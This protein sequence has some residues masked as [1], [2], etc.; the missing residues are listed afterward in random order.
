MELG[1]RIK[2]YRNER[3]LSQDELAE[4]VFV[5]R[6]TVSNW[7]T[8]KTYPDINSLLLLS[9]AFCVSLDQ[10]VKGDIEIMKEEID[11]QEFAQ[12]QRDSAIYTVLFIAL[13]V[14][15]IPLAKF[16]GWWGGAAYLILIAV[17]MY[18]AVR[19]EK[20]KK[21]YDIQTY[22]EIVAFTEGRSMDDIEKARESGKRPYQKILLAVGSALLCFAFT[23]LMVWLLGGVR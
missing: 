7:E 4:R 5:S 16:L 17:G 21:K 23:A 12:F 20:Y 3:A 13:I 18:Y 22:R 1:T 6:Q 9:E 10:L 14:L 2:K 8:G 11:A 15:P 19:V